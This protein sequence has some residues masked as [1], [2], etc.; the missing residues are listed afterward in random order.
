MREGGCL[1]S[2]QNTL[3]TVLGALPREPGALL[4]L[5]FPPA[6]PEGRGPAGL[7]PNP[8]VFSLL[9]QPLPLGEGDRMG[10]YVL[11]S[12]NCQSSDSPGHA[13]A[14]GWAGRN[15]GSLA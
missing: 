10:P 4:G 14:P 12:R 11:Q 9:T 5:S 1:R 2:A 6:S 15:Q 3:M 13:G 7:L 8:A